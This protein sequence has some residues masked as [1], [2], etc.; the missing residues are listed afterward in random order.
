MNDREREHHNTRP[1]SFRQLASMFA[2]LIT[3]CVIGAFFGAKVL[4]PGVSNEELK[5]KLGDALVE[6]C[7]ANLKYRKQARERSIANDL[8]TKLQIGANEALINVVN[9]IQQSPGPQ[10]TS[11]HV[12]GRK[13]DRVNAQLQEVRAESTTLL[14][15]PDCN[16]YREILNPSG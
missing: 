5:D 12:L 2:V 10:L 13:L 3:L 15:L 9:E 6:N 4:A 8:S 14:P 1:F 7:E 11:I 16:A